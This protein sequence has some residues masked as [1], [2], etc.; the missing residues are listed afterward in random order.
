MPALRRIAERYGACAKFMA[1]YIAEAHARDE[2]P[3]GH[4]VSACDQ[5]KSLEER[6]ELAEKLEVFTTFPIPLLVDSISNS[7]QTGYSSWPFRFYIIQNGKVMVKGQ[8]CPKEHA[9]RL[10]DVAEW[11]EP[12]LTRHNQRNE[13]TEKHCESAN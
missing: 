13:S 9:Y 10:E 11:L 3:V 1:V 4:T 8:P 5:P 2:W 7:F 6:L 12:V